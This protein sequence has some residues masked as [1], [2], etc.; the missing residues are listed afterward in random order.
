M[1]W[2]P[3]SQNLHSRGIDFRCLR[4]ALPRLAT[5]ALAPGEVAAAIKQDAALQLPGTRLSR[6]NAGFTRGSCLMRITCSM[7][8][9]LS[10]LHCTGSCRMSWVVQ[11]NLKTCLT[12]SFKFC[13]ILAGRKQQHSAPGILSPLAPRELHATA[14]KVKP[15]SCRHRSGIRSFANAIHR[16]LVQECPNAH[17]T[18]T[19]LLPASVSVQSL[20]A[21]ISTQ[22][23]YSGMSRTPRG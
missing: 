23:R 18:L 21:S 1:S 12:Y 6:A 8:L 10:V 13:D 7:G 16:A 15:Q 3:K 17:N 4:P 5:C 22:E 11:S 9:V 19:S 2:K 20:Q 14:A